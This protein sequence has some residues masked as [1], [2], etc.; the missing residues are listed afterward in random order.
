V[1]DNGLPFRNRPIYKIPRI[2]YFLR[3]MRTLLALASIAALVLGYGYY[4]AATH[5]WLYIHL[6]DTAVKPYAG[7][8]R[9]GEPR[10]LDGNGNFLASAKSDKKFGVVRLIHPEIGDCAAEERRASTP[11]ADGDRWRKCFETM[12]TWLVKWSDQVRFADV[13]FAGCDLKSVPVTVHE[14][15]EGLV[16]LVGAAAAYR[17][18]AA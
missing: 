9:D 1:V 11:L 16:A 8:I 7:N 10:L 14:T 15:R 5:G 13:T 4:H 12:S 17:R 2:A 6:M 3:A 18:Q